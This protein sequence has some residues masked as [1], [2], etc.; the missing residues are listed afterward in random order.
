M[1]VDIELNCNANVGP[2]LTTF[3]TGQLQYVRIVLTCPVARMV[4]VIYK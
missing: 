4:D 2:F 3:R 1:F